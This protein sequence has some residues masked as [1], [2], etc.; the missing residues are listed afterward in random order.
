MPSPR[1]RLA[2]LRRL[3]V[4]QRLTVA[5]AVLT[6]IV[7]AAV[8]LT[9]YAVESGRLD[10]V[11]D[12]S[13]DH[14]LGHLDELLATGKDPETGGPFISSDALVSAFLGQSLAGQNE[15][16]YGYLH[17]GTRYVQGEGDAYLQSTPE[18]SA[19]VESLLDEG[20]VEDLELDGGS[21]RVAVRPVAID[22]SP[23]A[24]VA[25]RNLSADRQSLQNLLVTYAALAVLAVLVVAAL[26]S[27]FA[28][29]LLRPVRRLRDTAL[30]ISEGDVSSRLLV[31]GND[32]LG[33]L[34]RTFNAM[35]DRLDAALTAQRR[36]LDDAGHELRTPLTVL[37]GHLEV[38][39]PHDA[40]DVDET[41][42]MLLDEV[43][44]MS[45]LVED[46]LVL[47]R[48]RRPDFVQPEPTDVADLTHG[49]VARARALGDRRWQ[50][51]EAAGMTVDLDAQRIVQAMLQ[52]TD[53]AVRHT[54]PGD[55]IGVGSAVRDGRLELWVR[56]TGPGVEPQL[57]DRLFERYSQGAHDDDRFGLGLGLSI[58]D[59]IASAHGGQVVLDD[60]ETGA[61]VR[62]RIP[63]EVTS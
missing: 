31:T 47:A 49:V 57:R 41:R 60:T 53:N 26:S 59:A 15:E 62:L 18:F 23:A 61:T 38:L 12:E 43:D 54:G 7:L 30:Q 34:Q 13:L 24:I 51:D 40:A 52:L 4:R 1:E 58:V 11:A 10:E 25:V 14:Q 63:V 21:Y 36:L 44:R 56:D 17:D 50:V 6:A 48:A 39:D 5:V 22:D 9:M 27:W 8:G 19:A 20:G 28:G 35:L 37:R 55:E 46:L 32:D 29:S 33:D 42:G 16:L 2:A 3:S 45:R